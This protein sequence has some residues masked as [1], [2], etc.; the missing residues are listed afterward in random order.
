MSIL[1]DVFHIVICSFICS[2]IAFEKSFRL[3]R[4]ANCNKFFFRDQAHRHQ[5]LRPYIVC[6]HNS[7]N[8]PNCRS[9]FNFENQ[10]RNNAAIRLERQLYNLLRNRHIAIL[11]T[12]NISKLSKR[13]TEENRRRKAQTATN[14]K[15]LKEFFKDQEEPKSDSDHPEINNSYTAWLISELDKYKKK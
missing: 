14:G 8:L 9:N 6:R 10:R 1:S 11:K 2:R 4:C 7:G 5:I 3:N 15:M 12:W 13:F